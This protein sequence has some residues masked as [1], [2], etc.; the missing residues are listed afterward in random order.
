MS[1]LTNRWL[2]F[3]SWLKNLWQTPVTI[4]DTEAQSTVVDEAKFFSDQRNTRHT[5]RVN[6]VILER[7]ISEL[8]R[9]ANRATPSSDVDA[10]NALLE[11]ARGALLLDGGIFGLSNASS[12]RLSDVLSLVFLAMR[13]TNRARILLNACR[14]L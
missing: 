10:A 9:I 2:R 13:Q 11:K 6:L 14:P 7:E 5:I 12:E 1:S 3:T 4:D 8:Q